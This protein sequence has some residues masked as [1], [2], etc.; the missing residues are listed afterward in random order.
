VNGSIVVAKDVSHERAL[1]A[2]LAQAQRTEAVGRLAGGVAHDFNNL[3]TAIRGYG[4]LTLASLPEDRPER[5]DIVEILRAA[6][7][8][9]DLTRA[10]LA[11]SRRQT[12]RPVAVDLNEAVSGLLPMLGRTI[13]EHVE[14]DVSLDPGIGWVHADRSQID[15]IV[16]NLVLNARDAMETGGRLSI[17]T[18]AVDLPESV[19]ASRPGAKPGSWIRLQVADTGTGMTPD[20]LEHAFEPFFTTKPVDKGTG[21]GLSTVMGVVQQSDGFVTVDSA[22]GAG[23]TISVYLPVVAPDVESPANERQASPPEPAHVP[24]CAPSAARR[25]ILLV[26]DEPAVRALASRVLAGAGYEVVSATD[27]LDA[28]RAAGGL[29]GIDLLLTDLVMPGLGGLEVARRLAER[30]PGVPTAFMSGYSAGAPVATELPGPLLRKPF[31]VS[32][33]L[34]YVSENLDASAPSAANC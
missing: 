16:M 2:Q 31:T 8:A 22:L 26:E 12:L 17:T 1:E 20:V 33:L 5:P 25:T 15:Q 9:A 6:N 3:L 28:L 34:A 4:E 13:G 11:F 27:G 29:P 21:L 23:T 10:L 32:G 30:W 18:T 24:A 7:R 14:L 19:A